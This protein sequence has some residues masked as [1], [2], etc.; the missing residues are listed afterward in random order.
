MAGIAASLSA[1]AG[2]EVVCVDPHAPAARAN[3]DAINP[4]AIAFD[5]TDPV[6]GLELRLM[7][8]RPGLVLIGVDPSSDDVL[9]LSSRSARALSAADLVSV[10][11]QN[12]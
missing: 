3:L 6:P 2:L 7:H 4:A 12:D 5:L 11:C 9:V 10:I 1:D 8:E